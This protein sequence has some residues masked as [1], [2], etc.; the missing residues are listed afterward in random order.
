MKKIDAQEAEKQRAKMRM[1]EQAGGS[2]F[3]S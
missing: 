3:K 1:I 2:A